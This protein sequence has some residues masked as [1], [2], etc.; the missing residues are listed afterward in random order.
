[1]TYGKPASNE[2]GVGNGYSIRSMRWLRSQPFV[3]GRACGGV[4]GACEDTA[5]RRRAVRNARRAPA[6]R[7][8]V[9]NSP[10]V[11]TVKL[12]ARMRLVGRPNGT[13]SHDA[14]A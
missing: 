10:M 11:R 9:R 6:A 1:M 12:L 13:A 14:P 5:D 7:R 2:R 3:P 8:W 4:S